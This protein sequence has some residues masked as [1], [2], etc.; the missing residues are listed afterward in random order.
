MGM[1]ALNILTISSKDQ[2][3]QDSPY[4]DAMGTYV[5]EIVTNVE[6]LHLALDDDLIALSLTPCLVSECVAQAA[7]LIVPDT[8]KLTLDA[9]AGYPNGRLLN[10]PVMDVILAVLLLD[11]TVHTAADLVGVNP[12]DNDIE[13]PISFPYLAPAN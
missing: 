7:P 13:F 12:P 8:L 2:Y 9:E 3:N 6:G 10:D 1:P 5:D 11:L 4:G